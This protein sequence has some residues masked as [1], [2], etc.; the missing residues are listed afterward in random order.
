[1]SEKI[2]FIYDGECPFCNHFAELIELKGDIDDLELI[3]GRENIEQLSSLYI[4]GYDLNDG[5]ILLVNRQVL[6]G[7]NAINWICSQLND[8]SDSLLFILKHIFDSKERSRIIFPLLIWSRR[9]LLLF[10]GVKWSPIN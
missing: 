2:A 7:A 9:I 8:P 6:H 5:A 3:N 4:K 10:K 1:M